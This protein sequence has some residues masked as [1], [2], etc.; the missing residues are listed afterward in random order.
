MHGNQTVKSAFHSRIALKTVI[1]HMEQEPPYTS[2]T[3]RRQMPSLCWAAMEWK[4]P[5]VAI[6]A[7]DLNV[8]EPMH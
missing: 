6:R 4:E 3:L 2:L 5:Q 7:R 8:K 1:R